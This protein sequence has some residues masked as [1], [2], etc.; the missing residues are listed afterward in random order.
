[1]SSAV[2]FQTLAII[3]SINIHYA[4]NIYFHFPLSNQRWKASDYFDNNISS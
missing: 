3:G 4:Y 2:Y 1:M